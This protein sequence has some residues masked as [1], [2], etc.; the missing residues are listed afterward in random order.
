MFL[1][2]HDAQTPL[3][4]RGT[5]RSRRHRAADAERPVFPLNERHDPHSTDVVPGLPAAA[6]ARRRTAL[7]AV[8][9]MLALIGAFYVLREH[10]EHVSG[11][12]AY[13]LL[14][15]CPLLHLFGHGDHRR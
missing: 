8:L 6:P 7:R 4:F 11:R 14:L 15:V 3:E 1:S 10:W 13:L 5:K 2:A 9:L 12:W